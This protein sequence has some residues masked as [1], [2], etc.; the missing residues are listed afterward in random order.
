MALATLEHLQLP[1]KEHLVATHDSI[2]IEL[3]LQNFK[4]HKNHWSGGNERQ[5]QAYVLRCACECDVSET[6]LSTRLGRQL[7][8]QCC[9]QNS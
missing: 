6:R 9:H 2:H 4:N 7:L 1:F 8:Q 5:T 3:L